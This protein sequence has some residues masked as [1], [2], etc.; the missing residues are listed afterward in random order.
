VRPNKIFIVSSRSR[1]MLLFF[2]YFQRALFFSLIPNPE[3]MLTLGSA[4]PIRSAWFIWLLF[5]FL[6]LLTS[7]L[8]SAN[9]LLLVV[10]QNTTLRLSHGSPVGKSPGSKPGASMVCE[11]VHVHGLSRLKNLRKIA[12]TV[13]VKV[14]PIN[15]NVRLPSIEICFHRNMSLEVGMCPQ[16]RWEKV[17]KGFW[18]R[19][20]SPF[21]YKLLDIRTS[22][23]SL[24]NFEV[25][26][27][28]EFF[29]YRIIFLI[30]GIILMSLASAL[31]KS[32]AFYYSSAMA[33]GIVLVILM[34]LF[35][36]MKLLP[37]GRKSSLAI[38]LYSTAVGLGTILLRYIPGLFR[39]IV[40]EIGISEDMYNPLAIFL[41]A[42]IALTGAWLGFWVVRKLVLTEDGSV[43]ISTSYFVAWA[44][45]ILA[46]VFILQSSIDP[47]LAI[48]AFSSGVAVSSVLK[49]FLR[50]RFLRRLYRTLFKSPKKN[51]RRSQVPELSHEDSH[52]EYTYKM[53]SDESSKS[54]RQLKNF[55]LTSCKSPGQ[56]FT[57]TSPQQLSK[58]LF[59]STFH[60]T[61]ERRQFSKVEWDKFTKDSTEK[62]LEELVGSPDF[63]KW[64]LTNAERITVSPKTG[65]ADRVH[66]W[67][68]WS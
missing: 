3:T 35:Q 67:M 16:G 22:G 7:Y 1:R 57:K 48:A 32:L 5:L 29:L 6:S 40:A 10:D 8:V 15:S 31:G 43:D 58:K 44:I 4:E 19:P 11:R 61:P 56:G 63:S 24:E 50:L 36:G 14:S 26:I 12:H 46:A 2:L 38:F 30:L 52:D 53:Q 9:E 45:R 21:D 25:S 49:R 39:S 65:R 27:E 28:E 13:K 59:P 55:I 18:A 17:G 47:L 51:R 34:V 33:V 23:S 60:T 64:I 62:A 68:S 42:F 66:S 37:T 41:L 20:M 54:P